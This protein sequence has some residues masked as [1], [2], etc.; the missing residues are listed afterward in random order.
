MSTPSQASP[1]QTTVSALDAAQLRFDEVLG[2]KFAC[3]VLLDWKVW[4]MVV[5][6]LALS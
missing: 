5:A 1:L 4:F 6:K 3:S 2:A